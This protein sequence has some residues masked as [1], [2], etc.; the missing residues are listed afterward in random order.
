MFCKN[1]GSPLPDGT[2]V[3]PVCSAPV[4][5]AQPAAPTPAPAP[6][7]QQPAP[8]FQQP[9]PGFQK[10][11]SASSGLGG[12]AD[13][14]VGKTQGLPVRLIAKIALILALVSFALP[15]FSIGVDVDYIKKMARTGGSAMGMDIDTDDL[16]EIEEVED[17]R[18]GSYSGFNAM[19]G[20][21]DSTKVYGIDED[22]A[23][24]MTEEFADE[25][26]DLASG[27]NLSLWI[28]FL[29][30]AGAVAVLFIS[31]SQQDKKSVISAGLSAGSILFLILGRIR[32]M[33]NVSF[34]DSEELGGFSNLVDEM[35]KKLFESHIRWGFALCFLFMLAGTAACVVD[36]LTNGKRPAF[37]GGSAPSQF[38]TS[39]GYP[40]APVNNFQQPPVNNF[41][42][43]VNNFQQPPVN[44]AP[45][46]VNPADPFNNNPQQPML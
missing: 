11:A 20:H 33:S 3:C 32:F 35:M 10:P 6:A 26:D 8:S 24:E 25:V 39:G 40:Q 44:S 46:A 16:D 43:P 1:C 5:Q 4:V 36:Y 30:G 19:F 9:A 41:Q 15:F 14:I 17:F 37:I 18:W 42:P 12:V 38:P 21:L 45:P 13:S 34:F 2:A 29:L 31:D 7:F 23:E 27:I 22:T 28:S